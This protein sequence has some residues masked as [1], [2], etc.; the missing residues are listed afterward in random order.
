MNYVASVA[1]EAIFQKKCI[2]HSKHFAFQGE[3]Y[4][5]SGAGLAAPSA[6][7]AGFGTNG[8]GTGVPAYSGGGGE[9]GHGIST[10]SNAANAGKPASRKSSSK[11][12][13]S[14]RHQQQL[15]QN[16]QG[17]TYFLKDNLNCI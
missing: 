6:A 12:R 17:T 9:T 7:A 15:P 1:S 10:A 16:E 3:N 13:K 8:G 14:S 5:Q 2:L 11:K 4:R